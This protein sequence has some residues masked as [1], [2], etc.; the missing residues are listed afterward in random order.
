MRESPAAWSGPAP[1]EPAVAAGEP[2]DG[3]NEVPRRPAAQMDREAEDARR[4]FGRAV[5]N[6]SYAQ[7]NPRPAHRSAALQTFFL[8][9]AGRSLLPAGETSGAL[10]PELKPEEP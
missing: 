2:T 4:A 3:R 10:A 1:A 9:N 8:A 6:E 7:R 5:R